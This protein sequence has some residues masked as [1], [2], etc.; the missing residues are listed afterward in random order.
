ML[1]VAIPN[2]FECPISKLIMIEP[3]MLEGDGFTYEK[4]MIEQHLILKMNQAKSPK[5][6]QV[7]EGKKL[8]LNQTL[9]SQIR[10]FLSE[11]PELFDTDPDSD[12]VYFAKK[13]MLDAIA[14]TNTL[15]VKQLFRL[16]KRFCV[17]EI[18]QGKTA[19]QIIACKGPLTLLKEA[20]SQLSPDQKKLCFQ[21]PKPQIGWQPIF[22]NELMLEAIKTDDKNSVDLCLKLHAN[23][24]AVNKSWYNSSALHMAAKYGRDEIA[25]MLLGEKAN[26]EAEC[27]VDKSTPLNFATTYGYLNV[28]KVLIEAKAKLDHQ[29][30]EG[31]TPLHDAMLNGHRDVAWLLYEQGAS[32]KIWNKAKQ[33]PID[34]NS[35][36]RPWF[37]EKKS[38]AKQEQQK[39]SNLKLMQVKHKLETLE[40]T[41][42]KLEQENFALNKKLSICEFGSDKTSASPN[43]TSNLFKPSNK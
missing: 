26:I 8:I 5:T 19:L 16:D 25:K 1:K 29:D 34:I 35:E 28:V 15:K 32:T 2:E 22:L 14:K 42:S 33:T 27:P 39:S 4:E 11:N 7:L 3:M 41:V 30:D 21:V 24:Q 43:S 38:N 12:L 6:N 40:L 31:N 20:I 17:R 36:L 13:T 37:L 23:V 9:C 10:N 18:E